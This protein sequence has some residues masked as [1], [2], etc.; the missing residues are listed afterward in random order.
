MAHVLVVRQLLGK[1]HLVDKTA[2][3]SFR[4]L[5][6][7]D[8]AIILELAVDGRSGKPRVSMFQVFDLLRE[9]FI[10]L[11]ADTPVGTAGGNKGV[12]TTVLVI[13]V[14]A[15]NGSRSIVTDLAIRGFHAFG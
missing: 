15:F 7:T 13:Q 14:P 2:D 1:H 6:G 8:G 11:S 5:P 9:V 4:Y 3:G 12:K 10:D